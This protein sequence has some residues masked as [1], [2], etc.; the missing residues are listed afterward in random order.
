MMSIMIISY[1]SYSAAAASI[2]VKSCER[3]GT[4]VI[5][6]F[7]LK[8]GISGPM[9]LTGGS[10]SQAVDYEGNAYD[11]TEVMVDTNTGLAV[12]FQVF[13]G[14][15]LKGYIQFEGVSQSVEEFMLM[16]M[17]FN[18]GVI[19]IKKKLPKIISQ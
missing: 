11:S 10:Y 12:E 2:K 3:Q 6:H 16:T 15:A 9:A 8:T 19:K 1:S 18:D 14:N 4:T 13:R 7:I 17:R 5:C